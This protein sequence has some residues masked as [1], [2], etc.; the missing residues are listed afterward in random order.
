MSG[1]DCR[2]ATDSVAEGDD[3]GDC[4][5]EGRGLHRCIGGAGIP[6]EEEIEVDIGEVTGKATLKLVDTNGTV[7][8]LCSRGRLCLPGKWICKSWD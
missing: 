5:D 3:A 8:G 6:K 2:I 1:D 4:G 7:A